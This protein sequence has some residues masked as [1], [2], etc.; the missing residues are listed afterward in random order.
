MTGIFISLEGLDGCGKSTQA[1]KLTEWL[2]SRG[3]S[4]LNIREPG[5][6]SISEQIRSL[7]L[8]KKN[9]EMDAKTELLLYFSARAQLVQEIIAPALAQDKVIVADRFGWATFAYQ[10]YGRKMDLDQIAQLKNIACGDIWPDYSFLLDIPLELMKTRLDNPENWDRMESSGDAFFNRTRQGYLEIA[11][12]NPNTF[13]IIEGHEPI[14]KVFE[15]IKE[16][17]KQFLSESEEVKL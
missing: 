1:A 16:K 8:N 7:L 13:T 14:D 5:G 12:K 10:G 3:K 4:V 11:K 9:S 6:C 2:R 15:Q 17:V